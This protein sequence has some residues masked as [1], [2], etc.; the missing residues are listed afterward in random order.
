MSGATGGRFLEREHQSAQVAGAMAGGKIIADLFIEGEQADGVALEVE[1]IRESGG[2]GGGVLS[3]GVAER[4]VGHGPAE[5]GEQ[6]AAEVGFVLEFFDE[7][8]VAAGKN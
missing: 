1:E 3:F 7:V 2:E 6:V 8:T 5:V 4:A